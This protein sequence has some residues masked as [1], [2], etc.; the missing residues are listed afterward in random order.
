MA[1][2]HSIQDPFR[3]IILKKPKLNKNMITLKNGITVNKKLYEGFT[4][5]HNI[6]NFHTYI[7]VD[8]EDLN[9]D[10]LFIWH[11]CDYNIITGSLQDF[12]STQVFI[13]DK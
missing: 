8:T 4:E 5:Q 9:E 1:N 11:D 2:S 10:A 12:N 7:P 13:L 3:C 6:H